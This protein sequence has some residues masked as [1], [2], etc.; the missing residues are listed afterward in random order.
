MVNVLLSCRSCRLLVLLRRLPPRSAL[1]P[2]TTLFR[3]TVG[4]VARAIHPAQHRHVC[5]R[6]FGE[7]S[8]IGS[9]D[10]G[11]L[12]EAAEAD[13]AVLRWV[14]RPRHYADCRSEE[15]RVGKECRSR[16]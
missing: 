9:A 11:T 7:C 14:D 10:L 4:V 8:Q 1:F 3:S 2:Y 13:V 16:G 5:L 12:S 6:G 15:R